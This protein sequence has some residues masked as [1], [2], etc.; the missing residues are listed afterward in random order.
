MGGSGKSA[1]VIQF[2]QSYFVEDYGKSCRTGSNVYL[3]LLKL[4]IFSIT[5][6]TIEDSYRK[7]Y[8]V[9]GTTYLLDILDTAG[10]EEYVS[11]YSFFRKYS[12]SRK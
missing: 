4:T 2:I 8:L 7:Q 10:P 3:F 6:P 9:D 11:N 1:S 12:S 5:D